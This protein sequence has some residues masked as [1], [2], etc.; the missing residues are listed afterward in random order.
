MK[1]STITKTEK[2]LNSNNES[3]KAY[4]YLHQEKLTVGF[5]CM[6]GANHANAPIVM[7]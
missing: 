3:I 4:C 5:I 7:S 1:T 2:K 6:C